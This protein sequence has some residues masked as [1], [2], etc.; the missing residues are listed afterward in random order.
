MIDYFIKQTVGGIRWGENDWTQPPLT[1]LFTSLFCQQPL[2]IFKDKICQ[3]LVSFGDKSTK[4]NNINKWNNTKHY[5]YEWENITCASSPVELP[6][7]YSHMLHVNVSSGWVS[8]L[9]WLQW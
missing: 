7:L 8:F 2:M 3:T 5:F 4:N 9:C 1:Y 6:A